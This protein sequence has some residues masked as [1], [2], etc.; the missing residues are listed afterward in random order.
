[1]IQEVILIDDDEATIFYN[2]LVLENSGYEGKITSFLDS[3][4]AL[5]Y[6]K[7]RE[8]Q[9]RSQPDVIFLDINMPKLDGWGFLELY[10]D[11]PENQKAKKVLIMLTVSLN[12]T[13]REKASKYPDVSGYL[14]KPLSDDSIMQIFKDL[15]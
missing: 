6:L 11:L 13:D 4:K 14:T 1:M 2:E 10:K 8:S 3:E 15:D 12:P 7:S 9:E 5:E